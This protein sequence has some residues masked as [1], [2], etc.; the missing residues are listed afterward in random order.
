[1][2]TNATTSWDDELGYAIL[3]APIIVPPVLAVVAGVW[4][5]R[6]AITT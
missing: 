4:L 3:L 1:M 6:K 2:K 5:I